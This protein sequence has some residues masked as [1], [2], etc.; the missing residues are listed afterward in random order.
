[1]GV[2]DSDRAATV[3]LVDLSPGLMAAPN[4]AKPGGWAHMD[5]PVP[6][7]DPAQGG[8]GVW[9]AA[10]EHPPA[11][12]RRNGV[13]HG[14]DPPDAHGSHLLVQLARGSRREWMSAGEV[15]VRCEQHLVEDDLRLT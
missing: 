1:M 4:Y 2:I 14:A 10:M 8:G 11:G 15:S 6:L 9:H 12:G 7:T 3:A 13:H 5:Y